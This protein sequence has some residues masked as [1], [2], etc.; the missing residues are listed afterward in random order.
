MEAKLIVGLVAGAWFF[1]A[2][3]GAGYFGYH[4]YLQRGEISSLKEENKK[5]NNTVATQLT[6]LN[7]LQT[8]NQ[9][10]Y[11]QGVIADKKRREAEAKLQPVVQ[12]NQD[13]IRQLE[14]TTPKDVKDDYA[15]AKIV[16]GKFIDYLQ[17]L[18]K[19]PSEGKSSSAPSSE[20]LHEGFTYASNAQK[21]LYE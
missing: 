17:Q 21:L 12:Q 3:A 16:V 2:N 8:A 14:T 5:V 10:L 7:E 18:R 19:Q 13:F 4:W 6:Q 15:N 20:R 9:K 1:V 11:Q